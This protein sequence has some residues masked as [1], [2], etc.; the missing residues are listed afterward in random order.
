MPSLTYTYSTTFPTSVVAGQ[1][2]TGSILKME[3]W[4]TNSINTTV[5]RLHNINSIFDNYPYQFYFDGCNV[6]RD[7]NNPNRVS[8]FMFDATIPE[9]APPGDYYISLL[10]YDS[11]NWTLKTYTTDHRCTFTILDESTD[12]LPVSFTTQ[13]T[14]SQVLINWADYYVKCTDDSNNSDILLR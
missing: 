11:S 14:K 4:G 12:T 8:W 10:N 6:R 3:N 5:I 2:I 9:Y 1:I 7:P 13:I